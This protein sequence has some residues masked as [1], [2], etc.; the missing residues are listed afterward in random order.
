MGK[1]QNILT[2]PRSVSV[3]SA[4]LYFY[5]TIRYCCQ[6]YYGMDPAGGLK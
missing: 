5:V 3:C 4:F 6:Y 2:A 1:A